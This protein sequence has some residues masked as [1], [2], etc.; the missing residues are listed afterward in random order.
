MKKNSDLIDLCCGGLKDVAGRGGGKLLLFSED[1]GRRDKVKRV[2]GK[3][4]NRGGRGY[5]RN[6]K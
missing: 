3:D 4:Q 2:G 1:K 5:D 6:V